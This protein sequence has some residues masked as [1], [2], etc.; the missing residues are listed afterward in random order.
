MKGEWQSHQETDFTIKSLCASNNKE[1]DPIL[2]K[3]HDSDEL[4]IRQCFQH[5]AVRDQGDL[6]HVTLFKCGCQLPSSI[7]LDES[8]GIQE[9]SHRIWYSNRNCSESLKEDGNSSLF[10]SNRKHL[11]L[12]EQCWCGKDKLK[13]K[14]H[15]LAFGSLV[16]SR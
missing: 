1:Q 3:P 15:V 16:K 14:N 12:P 11:H 8:P 5:L 7:Q 9:H 2:T 4:E 13:W 10:S 6:A